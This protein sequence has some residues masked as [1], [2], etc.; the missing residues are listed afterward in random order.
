LTSIPLN[1]VPKTESTWQVRVGLESDDFFLG[2]W[3]LALA[4]LRAQILP[5]IPTSR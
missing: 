2:G 1:P 3:E 5:T 4:G